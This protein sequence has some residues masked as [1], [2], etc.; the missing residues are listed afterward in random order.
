MFSLVPLFV[1]VVRTWHQILKV[2]FL[3]TLQRGF[4]FL[5]L[6]SF[7]GDIHQPLHA[8]RTTDKGGNDFHVKFDFPVEA[9]A[10]RPRGIRNEMLQSNSK[11]QNHHHSWNLHSVWDTGII[12]IAL[13]RDYNNSRQLFEEELIE[14]SKSVNYTDDINRWLKCPDGRNKQCTILWGEESFQVCFVNC[15]FCNTIA[16]W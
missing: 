8:S 14:A 7:V 9:T 13:S 15:V 4:V 6:Y 5:Y 10:S 12:E 1:F 16:C 3:P 2:R 11:L